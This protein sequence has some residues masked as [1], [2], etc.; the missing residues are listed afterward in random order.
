MITEREQKL[1]NW[2]RTR[3]VATRQQLQHQF[4]VCH[5]TVFRTL[6]KVGYL[7][8]YNHN[9]G[10][11]TLADVPKFDDWGLWAYRD[12]R[13]S[14]AGTLL[15]T[16]V[17][18]AS[19]APAGLTADELEERLQ[20]P[21]ANLLSR[22]VQHGRL[23]RHVLRGSCT[24]PR[25]GTRS[26]AMA[27]TATRLPRCGSPDDD[28]SPRR[29]PR[30]TGHR[31]VAADDPEARRRPRAMGSAT[32]NARPTGDGRASSPSARPLRVEKKTTELSLL[33]M[34]HQVEQ[35]ACEQLW[36][37]AVLPADVR[38]GFDPARESSPMDDPHAPV[39]RSTSR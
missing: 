39:R 21:V 26:S 1:V 28:W 2:L 10:F 20:T 29:L 3:K 38:L 32:S 30:P 9:A 36:Q 4:Q 7:A 11:Y 23:Q 33:A 35:Q 8:S 34:L 16:L 6:K 24:E 13:F 5:M 19:Q 18:L 25:A 12:V 17:A 22:L 37:A 15:D 27:A 31:R 14:R